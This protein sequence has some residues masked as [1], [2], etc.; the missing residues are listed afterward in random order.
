LSFLLFDGIT[1][2]RCRRLYENSTKVLVAALPD[3]FSQAKWI[4][5]TKMMQR[6]I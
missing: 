3:T 1:Q 4:P 5:M 6:I 2:I